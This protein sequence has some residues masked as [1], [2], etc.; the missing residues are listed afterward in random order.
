MVSKIALITIMAAM[1]TRAKISIIIIMVI[2]LLLQL[3]NKICF[4]KIQKSIM[5]LIITSVLIHIFAMIVTKAKPA[6]IATLAIMAIITITT[7]IATISIIGIIA[8]I[9]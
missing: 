1:D 8:L 5:I 7:I 3:H 6:K 4:Y 2:G 9:L